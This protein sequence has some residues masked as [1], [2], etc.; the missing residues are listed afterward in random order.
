MTIIDVH[1]RLLAECII[2]A[3][4]Y[5]RTLFAYSRRRSIGV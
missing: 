4:A 3:E 1:F 2:Q 5:T